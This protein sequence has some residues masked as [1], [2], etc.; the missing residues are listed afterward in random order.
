MRKQIKK[1]W[2]NKSVKCVMVGYADD[3]S[4]DTYCMYD[5][6][7]HKDHKRRDLVRVE[8]N[9]SKRDNEGF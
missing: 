3:H 4:G 2:T 5:D 6:R 1:K 8:K 7:M 9:Q